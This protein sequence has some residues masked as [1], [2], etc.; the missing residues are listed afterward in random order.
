MRINLT[1]LFTLVSILLF[2]KTDYCIGDIAYAG[3]GSTWE[4]EEIWDIWEDQVEGMAAY[5]P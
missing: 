3:T 2:F 5:V 1:W 4:I